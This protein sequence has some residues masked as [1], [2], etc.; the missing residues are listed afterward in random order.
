MR[1]QFGSCYVELALGDITKQR[2]DAI[3]NAANSQLAGGGG[4]DGAIHA[5]GGPVLMQET[6]ERYPEGCP[7]GQAV[8]TSAGSLNAK[9]VFHA[10]GPVWKGGLKGEAELLRS[11]VKSCLQLA[12]EHECKSVAFP[13]ISTGIYGYPIDLAADTSLLA[14]RDFVFEHGQPELVR[15]VLFSEGAYGAFSHRLERLIA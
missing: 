3:V 11:A 14:V 6:G 4:V 13:A 1:V 5:A 7:A 8:A 10:V 12:L 9:H 2:V 15:F